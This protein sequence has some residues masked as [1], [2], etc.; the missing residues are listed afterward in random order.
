M[1]IHVYKKRGTYG[2][3]KELENRKGGINEDTIYY[4]SI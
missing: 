1:S 4:L 2:R 3:D